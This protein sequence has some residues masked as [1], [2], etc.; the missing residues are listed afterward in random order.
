MLAF[1]AEKSSVAVT[2]RVLINLPLLPR[3]T[4]FQSCIWLYLMADGRCSFDFFASSMKEVSFDFENLPPLTSKVAEV[5]VIGALYASIP[6]WSLRFIRTASSRHLVSLTSGR[7]QLKFCCESTSVLS[8][9]RS[10]AMTLR[11][12][13]S[14]RAILLCSFL[15]LGLPLLLSLNELFGIIC[16]PLTE[17]SSSD[18]TEFTERVLR[19]CFA[20]W[21]A[22]CRVDPLTMCE[23]SDLLMIYSQPIMRQ[24]SEK[25]I[26]ILFE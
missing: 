25:C 2:F 8:R 20:S 11:N 3:I 7:E 26:T 17:L 16:L 21:F 10:E 24:Y 13:L 18:C 23:A 22:T 19:W 6:Q 14:L 5:M 15:S 1:F 4:L 9:L 12:C